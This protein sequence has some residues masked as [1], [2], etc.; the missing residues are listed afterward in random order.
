MILK[1]YILECQCISDKEQKKQRRNTPI[2][3]ISR[4][5]LD[6]CYL[7]EYLVDKMKRGS[8]IIARFLGKAKDGKEDKRDINYDPSIQLHTLFSIN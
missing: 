2:S 8:V 5:V 1:I 6:S 4:A 7:Y 3:F